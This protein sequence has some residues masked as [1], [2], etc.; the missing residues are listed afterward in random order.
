MRGPG[1]YSSLN[2]WCGHGGM[3]WATAPTFAKMVFEISLK[4]DEKIGVEGVVANL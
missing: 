3:G 2:Q 4:I 1:N